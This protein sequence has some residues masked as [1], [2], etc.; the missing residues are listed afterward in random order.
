MGMTRSQV[1]AIIGAPGEVIA[2][3][4]MLGHVTVMIQW[5]NSDG[6]NMNVMLQN[7]RVVSK[8]QFGLR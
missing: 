3:S 7:R 5:E 8:A 1:T 6:G 4:E 2:E